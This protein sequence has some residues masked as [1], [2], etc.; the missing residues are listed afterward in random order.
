MMP[1]YES[2]FVLKS[3]LSEGEIQ[4]ELSKVEEL[5]KR[6]GGKIDKV[7]NWGK[8]RLAYQVAK[9][10]F[11]HYLFLIFQCGPQLISELERQYKLNENIIKYL[12][13]RLDEKRLAAQE[14]SKVVR[15]EGQGIPDLEEEE[16]L[17]EAEEAEELI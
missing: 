2:T 15:G 5:I 16:E 17:E 11:G 9:N 13:I 12:T 6:G 3:D 1:N 4:G 14:P 7:E 10:R 8:K